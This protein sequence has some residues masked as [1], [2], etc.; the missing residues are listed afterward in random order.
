VRG[1]RAGEGREWT[2]ERKERGEVE[3]LYAK[4]H[5]NVF[6]VSACVGQKP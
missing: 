6:I 1:A 4:F 2:K 3:R 5:M